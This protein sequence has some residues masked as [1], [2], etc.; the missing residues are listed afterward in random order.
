M[1]ISPST[2]R[3]QDLL[4]RKCIVVLGMH[5]SGTSALTR[6]LNLM[7]AALPQ[8]LLEGPKEFN[9]KGYFESRTL[10]PLNDIILAEFGS[11]WFD[12]G[13]IDLT[14]LDAANRAN[15]RMRISNAV[16]A[17]YRGAALF[18]LK[19]PR[20]CR[21]V[22]LWRDALDSMAIETSF[23]LPVRHPVEVAR[24]LQKRDGFPLVVGCLLWLRH[25]LEAEFETRSMPRAFVHYHDLLAAP[26]ATASHVGSVLKEQ[27]LI[28]DVQAE[29]AIGS[30]IDPALR[31][32]T[33]K[34]AE[35]ESNEFPYPWL[36]QTYEAHA[37]LVSDP[38]DQAV[39]LQLDGVRE[40]FDNV[41][42]AFPR[43]IAPDKALEAT[44]AAL[45][46]Q[47][48][49]LDQRLSVNIQDLSLARKVADARGALLI[50]RE[51]QIAQLDADI[52][53][54]RASTSWRLTAPLRALKQMT[55]KPD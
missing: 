27:R 20:I 34:S 50:H 2:I 40:Q 45:R 9:E 32:Y 26:A 17:E 47:V 44:I 15:L 51:S 1:E 11:S 48:A 23:A 31:H 7:G 36:R 13:R 54:L 35:L 25:V 42:A 3:H 28:S 53:E 43:I 46:E 30:F 5:R 8:N 6:T 38:G 14:S 19:D 24:S 29:Q 49:V 16:A 4:P 12:A 39:Q 41:A 55:S 52:R 22:S 10:S 21:L 33:A 18:V 37:R